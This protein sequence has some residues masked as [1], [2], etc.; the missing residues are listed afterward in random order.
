[1]INSCK[2]GYIYKALMVSRNGSQSN[3]TRIDLKVGEGRKKKSNVQVY[4]VFKIHLE[5]KGWGG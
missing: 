2:S 4:V 5:G 3:R 1:M